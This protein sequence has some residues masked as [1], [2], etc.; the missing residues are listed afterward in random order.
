MSKTFDAA[1][2]V[3]AARMSMRAAA[4]L[5]LFGCVLVATLPATILPLQ[6]Q[7]WLTEPGQ[8]MFD[9]LKS[10]DTEQLAQNFEVRIRYCRYDWRL[11]CL[12]SPHAYEGCQELQKAEALTADMGWRRDEADK[13]EK[14]ARENYRRL[15]GTDLYSD[16]AERVPFSV[17][18]GSLPRCLRREIA[19]TYYIHSFTSLDIFE[20]NI[21]PT[22]GEDVAPA[23]PPATYHTLYDRAQA[24]RRAAPGPLCQR[25][26]AS[27]VSLAAGWPFRKEWMPTVHPNKLPWGNEIHILSRDEKGCVKLS[28]TSL[29][30]W[31]TSGRRVQTVVPSFLGQ[32]K[33][34]FPF[35]IDVIGDYHAP[36]KDLPEC[37]GLLGIPDGIYFGLSEAW[38]EAPWVSAI[39]AIVLI[40]VVSY[41]ICYPPQVLKHP[42][43]IAWI[44]VSALS[45]TIASIIGVRLSSEY[46]G[47]VFGQGPIGDGNATYITCGAAVAIAIELYLWL[48]AAMFAAANGKEETAAT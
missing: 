34:V 30:D 19:A 4:V 26:L 41:R 23:F 45:T 43:L 37:V 13:L 42:L 44:P 16:V 22:F 18:G 33:C 2:I 36:A 14:A 48:L 9:A 35:L 11:V 39:F 46:L 1:R 5:F 21:G 7:V 27:G 3:S 25:F 20:S 28:K 29:S 17:F 15:H 24:L 31:E 40:W 12:V 10:F 6:L 47:R 8:R 32:L 38:R